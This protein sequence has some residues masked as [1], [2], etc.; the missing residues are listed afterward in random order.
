MSSSRINSSACLGTSETK[1][2]YEHVPPNL[3]MLGKR[4]FISPNQMSIIINPNIPI[5]FKP[6]TK[7][8]QTLAKWVVR[9][10]MGPLP[11]LCLSE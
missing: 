8:D 6:V 1:H 9:K 11:W 2:S 4:I 7:A 3:I 10:S 5:E